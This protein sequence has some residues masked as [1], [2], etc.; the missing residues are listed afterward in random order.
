MSVS[1]SAVTRDRHHG[2]SCF[3][4]R[5]MTLMM[6]AACLSWAR[7]IARPQAPVRRCRAPDARGV[8]RFRPHRRYLAVIPLAVSESSIHQLAMALMIASLSLPGACASVNE[9]RQMRSSRSDR[10][11][12]GVAAMKRRAHSTLPS[13]AMLS[14]PPMYRASFRPTYGLVLRAIL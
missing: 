11:C 6:R 12:R 10:S 9:A 2:L 8:V 1:G 3:S 7:T 13:R 5:I 14:R 4:L